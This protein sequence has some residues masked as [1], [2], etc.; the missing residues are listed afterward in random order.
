LLD[1]VSDFPSNNNASRLLDVILE[2]LP[3]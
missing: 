3:S 1:A 2:G